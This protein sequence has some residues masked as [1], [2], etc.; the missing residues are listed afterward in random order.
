[1][2]YKETFAPVAKLVTIRCLLAVAA[3]RNWSLHQ[4]DVQNAFLHGDLHEEVYMLP[5]PG[6]SRQGENMVCR[7]NKSLYGLKQASRNWYS[8]FSSAIRKAG[9]TQSMADYSLF[10]KIHGESFTAVL[11][12]VD[13]MVTTGN[14]PATITSLKRFLHEHFRI[15][16]LGKLKYFLG[17]K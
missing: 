8:K 13:D 2:D 7:L 4:L 15:K 5:P 16:D 1:M 10:T 6:Y 12:Y 11:I 9:F 3:A 17:G 14:D